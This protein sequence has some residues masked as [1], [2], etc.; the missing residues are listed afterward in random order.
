MALVE[1]EDAERQ[2]WYRNSGRKHRAAAVVCHNSDNRTESS[3]IS[4]T[5]G[6]SPNKIVGFL[7]ATV[8]IY[9][10]LSRLNRVVL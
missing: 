9:Y 3:P 10:P 5:S 6:A 7:K 1:V 8:K 4:V 2:S